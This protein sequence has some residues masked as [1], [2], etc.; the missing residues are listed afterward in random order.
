MSLRESLAN[1]VPRIALTPE[2]AALG[3]ALMMAFG[4]LTGLI[5][6]LQAMR[7]K[8]ATALGRS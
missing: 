4:L 6:A 7:L 1:F 5:P 2:I 8:I 3:I